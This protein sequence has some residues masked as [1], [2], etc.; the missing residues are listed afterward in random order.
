MIKPV[1]LNSRLHYFEDSENDRKYRRIWGGVA[2]PRGAAPG[3]LVLVGEE[4]YV[5]AGLDKQV[6]HTLTEQREFDLDGLLRRCIELSHTYAESVWF[7]DMSDTVNAELVSRFN[8]AQRGAGLPSFFPRPAPF[9]AEGAK[10]C[11]RFALE[12][13]RARTTTERKS[14]VLSRTPQLQGVLKDLPAEC[15]NGDGVLERPGLTAFLYVLTGLEVSAWPADEETRL[16]Q[17]FM[18]ENQPSEPP[19]FWQDTRTGSPI[20]HGRY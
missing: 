7:S 2:F 10:S 20:Q 17:V 14:I 9:L 16:T 5:E 15:A 11:F 3:A 4:R 1:T 19:R 18:E 6:L 13:L 8:R 12:A